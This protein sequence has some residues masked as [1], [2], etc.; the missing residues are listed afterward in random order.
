[1]SG[2]M[3]TPVARVARTYGAGRAGG[4]RDLEGVRECAGH[5]GRVG[6]DLERRVADRNPGVQ[7]ARLSC[8]RT[9]K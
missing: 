7:S 8:N 4:Y 3:R 5:W 1:M 6:D 9:G 2:C